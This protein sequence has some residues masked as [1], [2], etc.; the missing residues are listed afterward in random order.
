M[1]LNSEK[2]VELN[3]ICTSSPKS[4][5]ITENKKSVEWL[6]FLYF[7]V[8]LTAII[9]SFIPTFL[10]VNDQSKALQSKWMFTINIIILIILTID[11]FLRWITYPVRHKSNSKINILF[12]PF[13]SISFIMILSI[14]P[15]LL[16]IISISF[17]ENHIFLKIVNVLSITKILRIIMLLTIMPS[18]NVFIDVFFKQKKIL[19]NVFIFI[20]FMIFIFALIIYSAE[21]KENKNITNYWDAL[22]FTFITVSTIGYGDITPVTA[23]GRAIVIVVALIGIAVLAIPTGIITGT[24]VYEFNRRYHEKKNNINFKKRTPTIEKIYLKIKS[25]HSNSKKKM[26]L[27]DEKIVQVI[28]SNI[29]DENFVESILHQKIIETLGGN[30]NIINQEFINDKDYMITIKNENEIQNDFHTLTNIFNIGVKIQ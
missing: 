11:Y 17:D 15:T 14:L 3:Y 23:I 12:F 20:I 8:I 29:D 6:K 25:N 19:I 4:K 27:D 21:G 13:T 16:A 9:V 22:Y 28:L 24:F 26:S 2:L 1:F 5:K 30:E 18:F 7:F 10:D